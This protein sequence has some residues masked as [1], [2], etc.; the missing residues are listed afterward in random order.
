MGLV[1]GVFGGAANDLGLNNSVGAGQAQ[2]NINPYLA[3]QTQLATQLQG[4]ANGTGP[5]PAQAE[6]NQ[7]TQQNGQ[8]AASL[9]ASQ[10]GLNPGLAA[11]TASQQQTQ[12][13]QQAAGQAATMQANQQLNALGA[14]NGVLGSQAGETNNASSI[15]AGIGSGNQQTQGKLVGG[16]L[17]GA[18]AAAGMASGGQV[19]AQPLQAMN[20]FTQSPIAPAPAAQ[21]A[22]QGFA[23]QQTGNGP[24]SN[25]GKS[26]KGG[27]GTSQY[28]PSD[29]SAMTLDGQ[30][31]SLGGA[32]ATG[33]VGQAMTAGYAHGGKTQQ[34]QTIL[35]PGEGKL[36]PEQA[37]KVAMGK[38]DAMKAAKKV[39]GKAKVKGD[40]LSNDT[41]PTPM[42]AGSIVLPRSVMMAKN[43]HWAAH[44]FVQAHLG[45]P[46]GK[47]K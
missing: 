46:K 13:I 5:N 36:S 3:Q 24:Q 37:K 26:L 27:S 30:T 28:I 15:A 39:P 45:L 23:P 1:S 41:V 22:F 11:R 32:G 6:L 14:M 20:T 47:K 43:P 18:G 42:E 33:G 2:A 16:L 29:N 35:S 38:E 7:A 34:V 17:N 19:G 9:L 31:T 44:A 21:Q 40:S 12:A 4:V 25:V 10:R 8:Q